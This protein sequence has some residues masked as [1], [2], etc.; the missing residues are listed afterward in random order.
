M[1]ARAEVRRSRHLGANDNP[2]TRRAKRSVQLFPEVVRLLRDLQPLHVTPTT[3]V[4]THT[5]G[6]PI[7][8]NS[9]LPHWYAAQ[10]ACGI[11]V[12]GLYST[13]DAFVSTSLAAGVKIAWLEEQTGVAY[14]NKRSTR[15]ILTIGAVTREG[16]RPGDPPQKSTAA[17]TRAVVCLAV[18]MLVPVVVVIV[19]PILVL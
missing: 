11:R 6:G 16:R 10:R 9:F 14:A 5:R 3:P 1:G 17:E 12:R 4:F 13:K 2:K 7:E 18:A 19:D 8:P 15:P